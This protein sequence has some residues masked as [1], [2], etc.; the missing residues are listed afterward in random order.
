MKAS[1]DRFVRNKASSEKTGSSCPVTSSS[2][3]ENM[4][5]NIVRKGKLSKKANLNAKNTLKE[6]KTNLQSPYR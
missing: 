6:I 5:M 1:A 4:P 2:L 3:P